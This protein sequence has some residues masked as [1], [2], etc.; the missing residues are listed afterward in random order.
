[1][2]DTSEVVWTKILSS[3]L[4]LIPNMPKLNFKKLCIY[5]RFNDYRQSLK[6]L[7]R[8]LIEIALQLDSNR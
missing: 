5:A 1:M 8:P 7:Q 4:Q 3:Q 2:D 6:D